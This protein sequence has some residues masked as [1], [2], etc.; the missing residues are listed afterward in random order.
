M[1]DDKRD[2]R[3]GGTV[4]VQL[5]PGRSEF[6]LPRA[7]AKM[8]PGCW[9]SWD[10]GKGRPLSRGTEFCLLR[11]CLCIPVRHCSCARSCPAA[12]TFYSQSTADLFCE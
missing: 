2:E 1:F 3:R 9:K 12:D 5:Q 6:E 11:M 4:T 8:S 7:R 10:S